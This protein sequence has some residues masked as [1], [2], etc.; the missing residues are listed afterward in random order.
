MFIVP[1]T[2]ISPTRKS[3]SPTMSHSPVSRSSFSPIST[4]ST[5][6]M[7]L[8]D[9]YDIFADIYF[10][11][12]MKVQ[13]VILTKVINYVQHPVYT[14]LLKTMD[15]DNAHHVMGY[16]RSQRSVEMYFILEHIINNPLPTKDKFFQSI[17]SY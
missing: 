10:V 5:E 8:K 6:I 11:A 1:R 4:Q 2:P 13:N 16:L 17:G 9:V 15:K 3:M 14:H 12:D 7:P